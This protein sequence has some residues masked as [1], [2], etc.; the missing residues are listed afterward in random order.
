MFRGSDCE[1]KDDERNAYRRVGL[2]IHKFNIEY[3]STRLMVNGDL[4]V[5]L[6][7]EGLRFSNFKVTDGYF[8]LNNT[9]LI[10]VSHLGMISLC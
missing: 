8:K 3:I 2:N 9:C 5:G 6:K 1:D 10:Q 4:H 7:T